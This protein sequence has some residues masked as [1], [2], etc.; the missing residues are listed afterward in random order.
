M[1]FSSIL[2]PLQSAVINL[3]NQIRD[4]PEVKQASAEKISHGFTVMGKV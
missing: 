2:K 3:I 1:N 4:V